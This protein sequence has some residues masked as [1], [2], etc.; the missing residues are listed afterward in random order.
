M[1]AIVDLADSGNI[2]MAVQILAA[3]PRGMVHVEAGALDRTESTDWPWGVHLP[4]RNRFFSLGTGLFE[5]I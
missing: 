5:V 1:I 2:Y 4:Y 3:M